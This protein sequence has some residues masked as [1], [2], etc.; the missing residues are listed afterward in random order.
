MSKLRN[1]TS[2]RVEARDQGKVV[3]FLHLGKCLLEDWFLVAEAQLAVLLVPDIH[4]NN[5][6]VLLLFLGHNLLKILCL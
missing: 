6:A 3:C 4:Q 5:I 1:S 2:S